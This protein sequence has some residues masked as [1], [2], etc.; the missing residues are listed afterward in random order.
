[1]NGHQV[2]RLDPAGPEM[3]CPYCLEYFPLTVE[4]WLIQP[5]RVTVR[6]DRCRSCHNER[7]KLYQALR[8]LDPAFRESEKERNRAYRNWY[9]PAIRKHHP[10]LLE[11]YDRDRRE[12]ERVEARERHAAAA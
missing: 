7:N 9:R 10:E 11:A 6:A 2:V 1:M 4:Y 8:R 12:R 3:L 5:D